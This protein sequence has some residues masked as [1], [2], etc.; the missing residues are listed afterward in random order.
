MVKTTPKAFGQCKVTY[1]RSQEARWDEA[2]K[3]LAEKLGNKIK[4]TRG[5][6]GV[7]T[8]NISMLDGPDFAVAMQI[9]RQV[10]SSDTAGG[11]YLLKRE[12]SGV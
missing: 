1:N 7:P 12:L 3:Q 6:D 11:S 5:R 2:I 10:L 9:F 8:V 4:I